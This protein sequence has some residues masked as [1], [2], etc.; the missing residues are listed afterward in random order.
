MDDENNV[1]SAAAEAFDVLQELGTKTTDQT[2]LE[3][4]RQ[5]GNGSGTALQALTGFMNVR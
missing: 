4:L 1:R 2:I 5:P 3:A